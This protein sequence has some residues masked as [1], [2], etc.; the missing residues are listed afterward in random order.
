M[1]I[2]T[3]TQAKG[4]HQKKTVLW[5]CGGEGVRGTICIL[6]SRKEYL[7]ASRIP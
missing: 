2:T 7:I 6:G 5:T 4:N 3:F 1:I